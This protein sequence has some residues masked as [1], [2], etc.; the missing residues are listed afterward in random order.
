MEFDHPKNAT[1]QGHGKVADGG[2]DIHLLPWGSPQ[3]VPQTPQAAGV[4][5]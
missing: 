4:P 3:A 2:L 5:L 1:D